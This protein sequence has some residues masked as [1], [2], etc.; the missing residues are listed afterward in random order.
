MTTYTCTY[1]NTHTQAQTQ[2]HAYLETPEDLVY[3]ELNVVV[4]QFL[5]LDD[6]VEV[7]SH[8]VGHQV[9]ANQNQ[10]AAQTKLLH[11]IRH[12]TICYTRLHIPYLHIS[13]SCMLLLPSRF[14]SS[15]R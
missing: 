2:T 1:Q 13:A 9:P 10:T 15:Q 11:C 6:I 4:R 5:T 14:D 7:R 3:E 8:Q 12:A